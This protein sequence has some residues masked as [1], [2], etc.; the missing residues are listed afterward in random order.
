MIR[1][2]QLCI[3]LLVIVFF[4]LYIYENLPWVD[5]ITRYK[6]N[7]QYP[8]VYAINSNL[9]TPI[10]AIFVLFLL[11]TLNLSIEEAVTSI[12]YI[13]FCSLTII[14]S[15]AT[16]SILFTVLLI[17]SLFITYSL[18]MV[19]GNLRQG[20]A[21][22]LFL[23]FVIYTKD[24]TR[25]V[26][27]SLSVLTHNMMALPW[28]IF[29]LNKLR[30]HPKIPKNIEQI[31]FIMPLILVVIIFVNTSSNSDAGRSIIGLVTYII[32]YLLFYNTHSSNRVFYIAQGLL[33]FVC[34][35]Y[36]FF[37]QTLRYMGSFMSL[38]IL[39][40]QELTKEKQVA[41]AGLI[42]LSSIFLWTQRL[43]IV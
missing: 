26:G 37:D 39:A 22:V 16:R 27:L 1:F 21:T 32:V 31:I 35:T 33:V 5:D 40:T 14:L 8:V 10:W 43:Q 17:S 42:L 30:I 9:N 28:A 13:I 41:V 15:F 18:D 7:F 19:I 6:V 2:I 20:M 23:F 29:Y 38:I 25:F 3:A 24:K 4:D 11:E 12:Q 36:L 34:G